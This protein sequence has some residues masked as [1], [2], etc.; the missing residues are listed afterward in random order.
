MEEMSEV[1]EHT[2]GLMT[3]MTEGYA[4]EITENNQVSEDSSIQLARMLLCFW[5]DTLRKLGYV[6]RMLLYLYNII[7]YLAKF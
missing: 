5:L 4:K 2:E 1:D 6:A 3:D 7:R